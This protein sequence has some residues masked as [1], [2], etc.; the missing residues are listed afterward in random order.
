MIAFDADSAS[1]LNCAV[2]S[3]SV[4]NGIAKSDTILLDATRVRAAGD[5]EVNLETLAPKGIIAPKSKRPAVFTAE[6][7][8]QVGGTLTNPQV[9]TA[10]KE[11]AIAAARNIYF[12]YGFLFDFLSKLDLPADGSEECRA[13]YQRVSQ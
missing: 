4:S 9:S 12:A 13:I 10:P 3:F 7:A 11:I 2:G 1:K 8:L 5:L 6:V